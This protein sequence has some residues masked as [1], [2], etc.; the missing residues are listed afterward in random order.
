MRRCGLR[1]GDGWFKGSGVGD[2]GMGIWRRS[3]GSA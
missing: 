2:G 3:G 1:G